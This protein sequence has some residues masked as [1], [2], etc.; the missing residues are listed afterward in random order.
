MGLGI[1]FCIDEI[2]IGQDLSALVKEGMK[3][4][5]N[6]QRL[7]SFFPKTYATFE[8]I[9]LLRIFY[10]LCFNIISTISLIYISDDGKERTKRGEQMKANQ[11]KLTKL[12]EEILDA[13]KGKKMALPYELDKEPYRKFKVES[14]KDIDE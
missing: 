7:L 12:A 10:F 11:L 13:A 1:M 8:V 14:L 4:D 2:L 9:V 5:P 6:I 3:S